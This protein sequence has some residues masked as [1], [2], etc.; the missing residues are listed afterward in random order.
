MN[1]LTVFFDIGGTLLESPDIFEII[2]ERLVGRG[3]DK[4][5]YDLAF[6]IYHRMIN[7]IRYEKER[8]P[9]MNIAHV[10]AAVLALLAEKHGYRNISYQAHD[11]SLDVYAHKSVLFPETIAVLKRLLKHDVRMIIASDND[12]EIL[13]VQLVKHDL[14][15]YFLDNCISEK[16]R[17]YKPA[18]G[19]VSGLKKYL[20][21]DQRDCYFVGD[22][23]V[24]IET[25]KRLGIPSVLV[26]RKSLGNKAGAD[27]IIHDLSELLPILGLK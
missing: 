6:K 23:S 20:P 25:G 11:I 22:D 3:T 9:F 10:H 5:T 24:D 14:G 18:H 4:H 2:T 17:A 13:D 21:D 27:Y 1:S 8:H 16:V 26:D 12:S 7:T 19:F 15:K